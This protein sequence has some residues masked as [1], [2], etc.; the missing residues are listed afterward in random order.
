VT[1]L[2]LPVLSPPRLR[3]LAMLADE[4]VHPVE[5]AGVVKS[6]PALTILV[7]RAANSALSYPIVRIGLRETRQIVGAAAVRQSFR[8]IDKAGLDG[9]ELWRHVIL[10]AVLAEGM[11]RIEPNVQIVRDSAFT[12]GL[13]HDVGRLQLASRHPLRYRR[14]VDLVREGAE[15][16]EAE[17]EALEGDHAQWGD[18]V[19]RVCRLSDEI[20]AAIGNHHDAASGDRL[21]QAVTRSRGIAHALGVGDGLPAAGTPPALDR[22]DR[23]LVESLGGERALLDHVESFRRTIS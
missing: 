7:I 20:R 16:I 1:T 2:D 14:A 13:L 21:T 22:D 12:A 10:C 15:P 23:R 17:H 8:N 5:V 11:T 6:D 9:E 19:A 4:S 18:E 3:A